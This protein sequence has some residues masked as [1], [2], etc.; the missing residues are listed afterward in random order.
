MVNPI[1]YLRELAGCLERSKRVLVCKSETA[2]GV[3]RASSS[4]FIRQTAWSGQ[5]LEIYMN[6]DGF[7]P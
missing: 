6:F 5:R 2:T 1:Y 3:V 7:F 4:I